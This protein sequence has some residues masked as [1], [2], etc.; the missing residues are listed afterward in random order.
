ML[1]KTVDEYNKAHGEWIAAKRQFFKTERKRKAEHMG[2]L[3]RDNELRRLKKTIDRSLILGEKVG[4]FIP[5]KNKLGERKVLP[6]EI[7][8]VQLEHCR[9]LVEDRDGLSKNKEYWQ[10]QEYDQPQV[11]KDLQMTEGDIGK[12]ILM[13]IRRRNPGWVLPRAEWQTRYPLESPRSH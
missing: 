5:V 12:R 13:T 7:L 9:E 10:A 6:E 4:G 11:L 3:M 8:Q 1:T 2:C